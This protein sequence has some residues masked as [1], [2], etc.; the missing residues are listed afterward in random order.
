MSKPTV[1]DGSKNLKAVIWQAPSGDDVIAEPAIALK[2]YSGGMVEIKQ[3]ENEVLLD[4]STL[5]PLAKQLVELARAVE[6]GEV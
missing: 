2:Q 6:R 4:V 1:D 5:R 3:G